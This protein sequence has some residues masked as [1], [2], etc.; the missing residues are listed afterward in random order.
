MM[1]VL[2]GVTVANLYYNQPLLE[3]MRADLGSTD[4]EANLITVITQA[5][6]AAGLFLLVPTGDMFSRRRIILV[7]TGAAAAMAAVIAAAPTVGVVWV[8][9]FFLGLCSIV[10]QLF[11]PIAGQFSRPE[12][13]ARNIGYVLSGLLVGILGARVVSGYAGQWIGWRGMYAV[14]AVL[15]ALST[16]V[17]LRLVPDMKRNFSGTYPALMRSIFR[18]IADQPRIRL[19]SVRAAFGFGSMLSIWSCMAFHLAAEPFRADSA[20][21]GTLGLCGVAGAVSASGIGGYVHR[22]GVRWF[23]LVGASLQLA[24]WTLCLVFGDTYAGLIAAIILVDIGVQCLQLSNQ[25]DCLRRLPHASN[26]ANTVFMTTYF[27]GG[28]AGTLLS[29][30]GWTLARWHGVCAVGL[31]MAAAALVISIADKER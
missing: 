1:A 4:G 7:T 24:A 13:K 5:G 18:I 3:M 31:A 26:R 12:N 19:N 25:S 11:I 27:I 21:V 17:A 10:P 23:S 2:A 20:M 22:M 14:V 8:A 16:V 6:Y 15:M 28:S 30:L 29:G 9:S